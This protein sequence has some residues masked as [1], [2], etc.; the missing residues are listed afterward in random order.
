V[1]WPG[2]ADRYRDVLAGVEIWTHGL[3][4]VELDGF[5]LRVEAT[6]R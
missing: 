5:A 6:D 3:T 4:V 2:E 1:V